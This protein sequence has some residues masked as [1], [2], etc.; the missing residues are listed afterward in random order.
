[1]GLGCEDVG[2]DFFGVF[3]GLWVGGREGGRKG[4]AREENQYGIIL[5]SHPIPTI[6][7]SFRKRTNRV[8]L[9][10]KR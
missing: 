5:T 8:A 6:T 7:H 10:A 9:C 1:V 2:V 4:G 3:G